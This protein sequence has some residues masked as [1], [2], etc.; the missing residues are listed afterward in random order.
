MDLEE[1][2]RALEA[3]IEEAE[4]LKTKRYDCPELK[5][6]KAQ[7]KSL[8]RRTNEPDFLDEFDA[9]R[10][11]S[12]ATYLDASDQMH[13]TINQPIYVDDLTAAQEI[14]QGLIHDLEA[15]KK[16]PLGFLKQDRA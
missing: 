8:V 7:T 4:Q 11:R 9:L 15:R 2:I 16:P 3:Q 12:A 14:V 10:F 6:W 1:L 5:R 13:L